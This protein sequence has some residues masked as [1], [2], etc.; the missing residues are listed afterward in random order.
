MDT[1]T[2]HGGGGGGVE[3]ETRERAISL[4]SESIRSRNSF[5]VVVLHAGTAAICIMASYWPRV[6]PSATPFYLYRFF[7]V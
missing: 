4:A 5:D 7:F 6:L 2:G 1:Q 3:R